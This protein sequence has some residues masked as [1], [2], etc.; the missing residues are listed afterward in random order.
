M[1]CAAS[2]AST[3]GPSGFSFALII[4]ASAGA[5]SIL[6]SCARAGSL[7][8]GRLAPAVIMVA[9]RPKVRREKP[10]F[11]NSRF[12]L[13]SSTAFIEPSYPL[14]MWMTSGYTSGGRVP[15]LRAVVKKKVLIG[16]IKHT[17]LPGVRPSA[18]LTFRREDGASAEN[19][20]RIEPHFDR[21]HRLQVL[22][23]VLQCQE[24]GLALADAMLG[25]DR[26]P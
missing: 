6:E 5:L 25:A 26:S 23:R 2:R 12:S 14:L 21:P 3:H 11:S 8:N 22:R 1:L 7:K 24:M 13:S 20:A 19:I 18:P 4:T 17:V 16:A 10:R 15:V 9:I